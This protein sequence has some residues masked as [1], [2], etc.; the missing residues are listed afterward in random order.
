MCSIIFPICGMYSTWQSFSEYSD[1]P[2]ALLILCSLPEG[3]TAISSCCHPIRPPKHQLLWN[4]PPYSPSQKGPLCPLCSHGTLS[5]LYLLVI[6]FRH[7]C[8]QCTVPGYV[9]PCIMRPAYWC[10]VL[11]KWDSSDHMTNQSRIFSPH[12]PAKRCLGLWCCQRLCRR[13]CDKAKEK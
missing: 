10:N 7:S 9:L 1:F 13:L 5:F 2:M 12:K 3:G 4:A 8:F 11:C 6:T